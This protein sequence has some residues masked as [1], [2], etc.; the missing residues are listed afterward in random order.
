MKRLVL[1][2]LMSCMLVGQA[3]ANDAFNA[4]KNNFRND[5]LYNAGRIGLLGGLLGGASSVGLHGICSAWRGQTFAP[6]T[7]LGVGIAAGTSSACVTGVLFAKY[8]EDEI[9]Q[10][11][12]R[13]SQSPEVQDLK[14][15]L[16]SF[17][18]AS[19]AAF[20][21]SSMALLRMAFR[22]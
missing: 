22:R 5:P 4:Y 10:R 15:Y 20:G 1:G 13:V 19:L 7:P 3:L 16:S 6:R 9:N 8:C 12:A 18:M 17:K 11:P 21:V 2:S 14:S